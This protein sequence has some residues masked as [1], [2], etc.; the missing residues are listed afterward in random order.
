MSN[1]LAAGPSDPDTACDD[2]GCAAIWAPN[3]ESAVAA[4]AI[5]IAMV[6]VS[7][8]SGPAALTAAARDG[9]SSVPSQLARPIQPR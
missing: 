5:A 3:P 2:R 4:S 7:E 6:S 8:A 1:P 9:E